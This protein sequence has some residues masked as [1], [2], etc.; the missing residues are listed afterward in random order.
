MSRSHG[1]ESK[2]TEKERRG[3]PR[4]EA[5][6]G[7]S[8][9]AEAR[10]AAKENGAGG[11]R[12]SGSLLSCVDQRLDQQSARGGRGERLW[13]SRG[14]ALKPGGYRAKEGSE[15]A[16]S[17]PEASSE[18]MAESQREEEHLESLRGDR[19]P[20]ER[21]ERLDQIRER[22]KGGRGR[23]SERRGEHESQRTE[24]SGDDRS[25]HARDNRKRERESQ[26]PRA[27]LSHLLTSGSG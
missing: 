2:R 24:R 6:G 15:T 16:S 9:E 19:L 3:L 26:E 21:G 22:R 11:L 10:G 17:L 5:R 25:P 1:S 20:W 13:Q 23:A 14:E 12:Q 27:A 4:G 8:E 7:A 18:S